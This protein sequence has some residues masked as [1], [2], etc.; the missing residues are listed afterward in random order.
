MP[1]YFMAIDVGT[2]GANAMLFDADGRSYGSAYREYASIYPAEHQ[3][4]QDSE[5]L[6]ESAFE[7]CREAIGQSRIDK[8]SI[9]AVAISSQR[10]TFG[11]LDAD[12]RILNNRFI[13]WQDNRGHSVLDEIA[14]AIPAEELYRTTGMPLT[15]T[16][17]LEKIVWFQRNR[18][19][20]F[21][22]ADKIVFPADYVLWRFGAD[23]LRTEATNACCSGMI[24]VKTLDWSD[25]VLQALEINR[26]KFMPLVYPGTVLGKISLETSRRSG[27]AEGTLIVS[28]TGDQ[29]CAAIGAGVTDEGRASLTLGTAGLL[30]VGTKHLE[31]EKCPGLMAPSSGRVGLYELEGI[32]LG[33]AA[34]YRWIRDILALPEIRQAEQ[35]NRNPFKLMEPLLT[36]SVPGSNGIVFLPFLFGAGFPLWDPMAQGVFAGLRFSHTRAD[37]LRSVVEGVTLESYDMYRQVQQAGVEIQSLTVTGGATA[38]PTW[39]QT[40]ADIIDTEILPLEVPNATLVASAIFAGIGAGVF[41]DV[42]EGVARMVRYAEPVRPVLENTAIFRK[43][44]EVYKN[45]TEA[46]RDRGVF[47]DLVQ[48]REQKSIKP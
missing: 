33:A 38:S 46:M 23:E 5:L 27:L 12:G 8:N 44:Y 16:Y 3:V 22:A 47:H 26:T 37:M 45:L 6:V 48:L 15:P 39:R 42:E 14:S 31:L 36:E 40:I 18:P 34:C 11:F 9:A 20:V 19:E 41:H 24:D 17:S 32:Q 29:Q 35:E 7:V 28:A 43:T 2:T 4:E 30:V 25:R 10:A 21:A 1:N 13:V